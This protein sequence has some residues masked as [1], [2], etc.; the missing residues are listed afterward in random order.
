MHERRV[1]QQVSYEVNG[2][3]YSSIDEVP[4]ECR[5]FFEDKDGNGIPDIVETLSAG[6]GKLMRFESQTVNTSVGDR[7]LAD[8]LNF[9]TRG[10]SLS[11]T[12][13]LSR[14]GFACSNCGY[15]LRQTTLGGT[16][17]ECGQSVGQSIGQLIEPRR[18]IG[19]LVLEIIAN[20]PMMAGN[21][22]VGLVVVILLAVLLVRALF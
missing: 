8:I 21:F 12:K 20:H 18:S 1:T 11:P 10:S 13:N 14:T 22:I 16:C 5:K 9:G 17:P 19:R 15:D 6:G 4:A 2:V 7:R 3:R